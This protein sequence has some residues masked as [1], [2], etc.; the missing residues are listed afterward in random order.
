MFKDEDKEISKL[1]ETYAED[2]SSMCS[3]LSNILGTAYDE[4]MEKEP[5][6]NK[7]RARLLCLVHKALLDS[8]DMGKHA[9]NGNL[10][11][12]KHLSNVIDNIARDCG[13]ISKDSGVEFVHESLG[14][15]TFQSSLKII[16]KIEGEEEGVDIDSMIKNVGIKRGG[17]QA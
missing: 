4:S 10:K 3:L 13:Y 17:A 5:D 9:G 16:D 11:A 15:S 7:K 8:T 6:V 14:N 12:S 1:I 2:M